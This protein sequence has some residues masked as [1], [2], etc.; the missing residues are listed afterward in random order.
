M[1]AIAAVIL[2]MP[3]VI[4]GVT[5]LPVWMMALYLYINAGT[6]N[7]EKNGSRTWEAFKRFYGACEAAEHYFNLKVK[8]EKPLESDDKQY[9]FAF[10]P[11]GIYPLTIYWGTQGERWKRLFPNINIVPMCA[12]VIF[13]LP[14]MR[15]ICLWLGLQDGKNF[16]IFFFVII[17][18]IFC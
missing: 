6:K 5:A 3:V 15:D 17:H 7:P 18:S 8:R 4:W 2:A 9:I 14:L 12:T 1:P 11:H 13:R 10:H 16:Y